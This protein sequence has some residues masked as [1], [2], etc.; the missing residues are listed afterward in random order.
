MVALGVFILFWLNSVVPPQHLPWKP[1]DPDAPIG[2]AT[3]TQLMRVSLSPN[4][5]CR[6]LA[7]AS[8]ALVSTDADPRDGP[9]PCGWE[10]A[11]IVSAV[12]GAALAGESS[13]QCPL[14]LGVRIWLGEAD[15]LARERFG[16]GLARVHHFGTYSCRRKYGRTTG[17]WSEHAFANAWDVAS[18]ELADGTLISVLR[19]WDGERDRRRFLRDVRDAACDVFRVTLS[20]DYNAAH[21]DHFHL[22]MGP[23]STCR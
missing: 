10:V 16:Q 18:F 13:M 3:R 12:E 19:D 7:I 5:V 15:R 20:P 14:A 4:A 22:D 1:L 8:T 9:E 11:R 17:G 21:A 6:D 23:A 2:Q